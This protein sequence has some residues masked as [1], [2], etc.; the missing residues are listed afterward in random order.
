MSPPE[1]D[2]PAAGDT[3]SFGCKE[4]PAGARQGLVNDVFST[5]AERYDLMN[6]LMSGG[7][8]RLWK[9]DLVAWLAPPRTARRFD[10][11]DV[12][13]GTGDFA[14]RFLEAGGPGCAAVLCDISP[15]MVEVGR[16]R[17]IQAALGGR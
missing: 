14:E 1:S 8:H 10:L 2:K 13:D 7:L 11:I 3:T 16:K 4:V 12:A 6:D 9:D 5:V 15:T 17:L